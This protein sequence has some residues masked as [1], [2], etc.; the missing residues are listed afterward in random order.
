[1]EPKIWDVV[2]VGSGPAG[3]VS[4]KT[5]AEAGL[6][7]L[8]LEKKRL[9]RDKVCS[10]LIL[11]RWANDLIKQEFGNIPAD[12]LVEPYK[13]ITYYI[14]SESI[15]VESAIPVGWRKNL[16]CWMCRG[17][18]K[19]GVNVK[20]GT[21]LSGINEFSKGYTLEVVDQNKETGRINTKFIIGADG[22]NSTVRK[23]KWREL[24]VRYRPALR[25]CYQ[26]KLSIDKEQLHWFFP[27]MSPSPR[28]DVNYKEGQ[29][30]LE[31]NLKAVRRNIGEI[32]KDYGF[33]SEIRPAWTDGCVNIDLH[34][35]LLFTGSFVPAKDDILLIG[36]AAA[37]LFPFTHEGIGSAL[38]TGILAAESIVEAIAGGHSAGP[39]YLR[40]IEVVKSFLKELEVLRRDMTD[41]A[42]RGPRALLEAMAEL[43][44]RTL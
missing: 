21:R 43:T 20:D 6:E 38:K 18:A 14:G 5:C 41:I 27:S 15:T 8:L 40:K 39:L 11:G 12:V 29:F 26:V 25:E 32:L 35:E 1:V 23:L 31:G 30:L 42:K 33:P 13:G 37:M 22:A 7:T 16:D 3:S 19:K 28:F 36:D 17:A 24:K 34:D 4:A 44:R 2:V 9:P 10:G